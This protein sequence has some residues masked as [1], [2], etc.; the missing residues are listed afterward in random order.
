VKP[1]MIPPIPSFKENGGSKLGRFAD[2]LKLNEQLRV[3]PTAG[4]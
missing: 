4:K 2:V 3:N 1:T